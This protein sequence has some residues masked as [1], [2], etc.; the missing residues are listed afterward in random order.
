MPI[1]RTVVAIINPSGPNTH[2][3]V[4]CG[5]QQALAV[6]IEDGQEVP[7]VVSASCPTCGFFVNHTKLE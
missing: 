2:K 1:E 3:C 7:K 5:H 4:L 6:V